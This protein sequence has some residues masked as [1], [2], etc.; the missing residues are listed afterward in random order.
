MG[1]PIV[2]MAGVEMVPVSQLKPHPKNPNKHPPEQIERLAQIIQYAGWRRF[3]TVSKR[4]GLVTVGHGRLMA[5]K[6]M[7]WETVPV[8]FQD[9]DSDEAE[10]QD[11]VADNSIDDWA[12]LD[13]AS[14]N[15]EIPNLGPDF[16]I[17]LLGLKDFTLDAAEKMAPGCDEDEVPE[18]VE[19]ICN[20]GDKWI[21]GDHVLVCG[22]STD[23]CAIDLLMMGEKADMVFTDPPYKF[24]AEG[25][26]FDGKTKSV[27]QA[28]SAGL[29][30][31]D[32]QDLFAVLETLSVPSI[33]CFGSKKLILPYLQ[34]FESTGRLWDLLAMCKA[35]PIPSKGKNWLPDVEWIFFSRKSGAYFDDK[36]EF[37][38]YFRAREIKIKE[39]EHGHPTEKQVAFIEP[40][41]AISSPPG[42]VVLD[43]F[44]GSGTTLI[45]CEKT[46]R[47]CFM[48]ELDPHYC[49]VIIARWEKYTGRKAELQASGPA[50]DDPPK[51][52]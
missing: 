27:R 12:E 33:Y 30:D 32:P 11:L 18:N 31:F 16:D 39:R 52:S 38:S 9:Y 28:A 34:F 49:D 29:A 2:H 6:L 43:L 14:I 46:N 19:T 47:K 23:V 26:Y 42:G 25:S 5:A 37:E 24:D 48:M 20:L 41:M 8:S 3:I 21:L 4:S 17:D 51:A 7:G 15:A 45:A 13:L 44:G 50:Q 36:Q 40:Y 10:Y 22:D 1:N 35:N